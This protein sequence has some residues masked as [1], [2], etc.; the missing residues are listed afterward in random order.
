MWGRGRG[1]EPRRR[2]RAKKGGAAHLHGQLAPPRVVHA[3]APGLEGVDCGRPAALCGGLGGDAL[4]RRLALG[5]PLLGR[6]VRLEG[7]P[8]GDVNEGEEEH[9]RQHHARRA[10]LGAWVE[11]LGVY[12]LILWMPFWEVQAVIFFN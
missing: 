1:C 8:I 10:A 3:L 2:G 11:W 4:E 7:D 9:G 12:V 5:E 6:R